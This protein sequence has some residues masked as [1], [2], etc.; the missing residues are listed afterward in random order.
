MK[1]SMISLLAAAA[2]VSGFTVTEAVAGPSN[3]EGIYSRKVAYPDLDISRP[4]GAKALL[5]RIRSA[6]SIVCSSGLSQPLRNTSRAYR[7]CVRDASNRAVA[8]VNSP[9]V[10]A[11]HNGVVGTEVASNK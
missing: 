11:L 3:D 5:Y 10:T 9:M 6:A 2:L 1:T 7:E 4:Q 8:D